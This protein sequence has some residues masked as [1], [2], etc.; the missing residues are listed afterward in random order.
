MFKLVLKNCC[1][2]FSINSAC[3]RSLL[4]LVLS[5][6]SFDASVLPES[7]TMSATVEWALHIAKIKA[8][9]STATSF[10]LSFLGCL[11]MFFMGAGVL[12]FGLF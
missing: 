3:L 11:T 9:R 12:F 1:D 4:M 2:N 6:S 5:P 10:S 7:L 8:T